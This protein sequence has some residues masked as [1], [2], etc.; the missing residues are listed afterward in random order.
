M[1]E[2]QIAAYPKLGGYSR[3]ID[4]LSICNAWE[5]V[6]APPFIPEPVSSDIPVLILAGTYDPITPPGWSRTHD[7][8][9]LR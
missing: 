2:T 4:E 3:H 9:H 8:D 6:P 1:L 7:K 5:L